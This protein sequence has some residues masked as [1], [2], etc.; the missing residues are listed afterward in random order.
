MMIYCLNCFH[1]FVLKNNCESDK[2]VC[3]NKDFCNIVIPSEGT[4]IL[5]FNNISNLIKYHL[6]FMQILNVK[7]KRLMDIKIILK[8]HLQQK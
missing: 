6:L 2:K 7:Y 5:Q 8:I 4:K 3:E 1:S